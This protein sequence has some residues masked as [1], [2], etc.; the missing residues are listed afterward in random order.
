MA[1]LHA[2]NRNIRQRD[3]PFIRAVTTKPVKIAT[4][5]KSDSQTPLNMNP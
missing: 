2:E 5:G 3:P 4:E 1:M